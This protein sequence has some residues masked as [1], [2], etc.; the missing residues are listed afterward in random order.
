M[1][2]T[3]VEGKANKGAAPEPKPKTSE[4]LG[5]LLLRVSIAGLMLLHGIDK[6]SGVE[7][8]ANRLED[9]GL[10]RFVALGVYV[11]EIIS[12]FFMIIGFLTRINALIFAFNMVVAV[13]L[14]HPDDI[15]KLG[16]HGEWAIELQALYIFGAIAVFLLGP[17]KYS[18]SKGRGGL[19]A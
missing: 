11:G 18:I 9:V 13:M 12:P 8:I 4:E 15:F 16:D 2:S 5:K 10:P 1:S 17:G 6:L 19:L 14:A 7:G 3:L